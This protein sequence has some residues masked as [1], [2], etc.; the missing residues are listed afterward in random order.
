[1]VDGSGDAL[2]TDASEEQSTP[3]GALLTSDLISANL[4]DLVLRRCS[5]VAKDWLLRSVS[6]LD[7]PLDPNIFGAAY[8]GSRRRLGSEPFI[9]DADEQAALKGSELLALS[10][11]PLDEVCRIALLSRASEY[12]PTEDYSSFISEL[13]L[14]GDN[15]ERQALLRGLIYLPNPERFL[16]TAVEA[17]RTSVQVIFEAIACDNP[18]PWRYFLEPNYNQ[19]VL[20]ALFIG[21]PLVRVVGI[22]KRITPELVRMAKDYAAERQAANRSVP[23]DIALYIT[24]NPGV[25]YEAI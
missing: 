12:L 25:R 16:S 22:H 24:K 7:S 11:H 1:M 15:F 10:Q 20:K 21:S 23:E 6:S 17:C 5:G 14:R 3:C 18:Y 4:L 13:Y 19:M 9:L 8:A 2:Y